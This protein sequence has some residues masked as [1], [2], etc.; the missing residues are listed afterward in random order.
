LFKKDA[1][2]SGISSD[3]VPD[4]PAILWTADLQRMETTPIISSG[5]VYALAGNGSVCAFDKDTGRLLW[6]NQLQGWVFQMSPLA[7]N[8]EMVFAATDSGLLAAFTART[9]KKLWEHNLTDK[10]FEAPLAYMDGR[11]YLGEGSAYGSGKKKFFCFDEGGKEL[12][13]VSLNTTGYLWCGACSVGDYLIFGQNDGILISANRFSGEITDTL[14]L[15]DSFRLSFFRENPGRVR[16]SVSFNDGYVYATSEVS[17]DEGFTWKIG[18]DLEMG[19]FED[20][21]WSS[22]TGFSTST[23]SVYNGRVYVGLGEHGHPGELA[24]L[25]DSGGDL[26]WSYP[27]EAGVKSSPCVSTAGVRPRILFTT[28]QVNGSVYCLEDAGAKGV[29]Q[30]KLNPP[31]DGYLLGGVS[32]SDGRAY[33][34]TEGDQHYGKLYC[35]GHEVDWPQFHNSARHLGYSITEAPRSNKTAWISDD[36]G[37]QPGS[38]VS[39]AVGKTFVNCIDNVTCLDQRSGEVLWTFPFN[40]SGDY[41]FG[42]TPV[43]HLGR[44]FFTS[45]KTYCLNAS[46]GS[47]IW[48]FS[49]PT[50]KFAIDGSPAI[51][52]GK[53]VVSDWDGHHYYCLDE[54]TGKQ[55]WNFTV[56]G[57]AQSTPAIDQDKVVFGGWDWGLGGRIYCVDLNNGSEIWSLKTDNSPS[58]SATIENGTVYMA[59]YNFEGEGDLMALSLESGSVQWM[60]PVTST[61][62]TPAAADGRIYIC[63]GCEGF[64]YP[65]T[66]CFD[67]SSGVLLWRAL[68]IGDWR[69][70]P[71]LADG[72]LFAGRPNFTE[73]EGTFAL[74]ATIGEVVWSYPG[75][76]SSP[77][78]ADGM[79]FTV[80]GGRVYAFGNDLLEE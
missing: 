21:G 38:S 23:P 6:R 56:V 59:T 19:T 48:S 9:G 45:N 42:F 26:I 3:R 64:S 54:A 27:V 67:S 28:A 52:D 74:N 16:A 70:S 12:W 34:G 44:V 33:F 51:M 72:L 69:C 43:Y 60:V 37:A 29:L 77:S 4:D 78:L 8:G 31:D 63:G 40:A 25:N 47:E 80:G 20:R 75:G 49:P 57:N 15:S 14:N 35:L 53:A 2:N 61:D 32:I 30:W 39:L 18:F 73:Y 65:V 71:A 7:S 55:L 76:G 68:G 58:G 11:L 36:I 13:N 50:G 5:R 46:D 41:A 17:A 10:R 62:A 66:S 1:L 22:N 24:C 79:L